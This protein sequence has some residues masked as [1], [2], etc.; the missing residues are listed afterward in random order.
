[1]PRRARSRTDLDRRCHRRPDRRCRRVAATYEPFLPWATITAPFVG[2]RTVSGTDG[3]D[4]WITAAV[5]IAVAAYGAVLLRRPLPAVVGGLA[6][7][8][9]LSVA[10]LAV[11]K[12]VD[13]RSRV[14]DLKAEMVADGDEFGFAERMADAIHAQIGVGLWLLVGAGLMAAAC[15]G[16]T[17]LRRRPPLS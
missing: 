6:A 2:T 7:L 9:G 11:W 8:G 13:L 15:V 3:T 16:R 12:I 5:G 4:G 1:V 14:A 17:L 10:G